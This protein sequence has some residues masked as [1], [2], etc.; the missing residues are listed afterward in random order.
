MLRRAPEARDFSIEQGTSQSTSQEFRC[1][2]KRERCVL[3]CQSIIFASFGRKNF[4]GRASAHSFIQHRFLPNSS[5]R[6]TFLSSRTATCFASLH[7]SVRNMVFVV[8]H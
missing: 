6:L 8:R 1:C 7:S 3:N 5:T 4:A 2:V